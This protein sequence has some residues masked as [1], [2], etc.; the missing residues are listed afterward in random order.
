MKAVVLL[1]E[2]AGTLAGLDVK[3]AQ[4]QIARGFAD[5][6]ANVDVR[7]VE[8]RWLRDVA[9]EATRGSEFGAIIAGGGDG[10]INTIANVVAGSDKAFG[11]LPLGTHN[12]FAKDLKIP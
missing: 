1:N 9:L 5:A 7:F 10:T 4:L 11:V 8:P 6:S 3:D 2:G 12:H